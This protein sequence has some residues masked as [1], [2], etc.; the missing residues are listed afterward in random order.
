MNWE[1]LNDDIWNLPLLDAIQ[2]KKTVEE[3]WSAWREMVEQTV[4]NHI[5]TKR[6]RTKSSRAPWFISFHHRLRRRR[7]RLFAAAKRLGTSDSWTS[8]RFARNQL[9]TAIRRSKRSFYSKMSERLQEGRGTFEWWKTAKKLCNLDRPRPNVPS[10]VYDKHIAE[11]EIDKANVLCRLFASN[12][13]A[14]PSP[15]DYSTLPTPTA[16]EDFNIQPIGGPE[17]FHALTHLESNKSTS[18][19]L[20]N[21]ILK[22]LAPVITQSLS[23]LFNLS[24][25]SSSIPEDWKT[26]TVLPIYKGKGASTDPGN[27]R[28]ISLLN[29]VGK[30]YE[31]LISKQLYSFVEKHRILGDK[32]FGFCRDRSTTDQLMQITTNVQASFDHKSLCDGIFLDFSKAFDRANHDVI[33]HTLSPW[34]SSLTVKWVRN[35]LT[36]RR[37]SV[38]VGTTVSA[39]LPLSA[40]VPQGSHLGPLLFNIAIDS[41]QYVTKNE[42]SLFADDSNI[43]CTS[44]NS[45]SL[46]RHVTDI[47][48]D[49]DKCEEWAVKTAS[50]FNANKCVHVPFHAPRTTPPDRRL[51]LRDVVLSQSTE[52]RHLG[53]ILSSTLNFS[54]HVNN[55]TNKFRG[56]I[57]LL[58]KMAHHLPPSTTNLLY[59]SYVRSTVEYAIPVW[60]LSMRAK[61]IDTINKLQ[62]NAARAYL[63]AK[64]TRQPDFMTPKDDLNKMAQWD[65]LHWRRQILCLSYFHHVIY[66]FPSLLSKFNFSLTSPTAR[67]PYLIMFPPR[68]GTHLA[69]SFLFLISIAWNKL[70]LLLRSEKNHSKFK[71]K[72]RQHFVEYRYLVS[73]IPNFTS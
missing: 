60:A 53:V 13:T 6:L 43:I 58:H 69:K 51:Q 57:F 46:S 19:Y 35:F 63:T 21:K 48:E 49:I 45:S 8:Y 31:N 71:M 55:I 32:Q 14:P 29:A 30:V 25:A 39:E 70:P 41:L 38:R 61:E 23:A 5:P 67:L 54:L 42:L 24:I 16:P 62:A 65:S 73:G 47:Q 68:A 9:V 28:P 66:Q 37:M 20:T 64:Q 44:R 15:P 34:C 26:A 40:G 12:S 50:Q 52:H 4:R 3:A 11:S 17:V 36:G 72:V 33:I 22:Q 7:D 10:L 2:S 56:R 59:K 27:Y 1:E 18:G